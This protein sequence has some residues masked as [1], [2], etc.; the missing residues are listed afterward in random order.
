MH[1]I[2]DPKFDN[3]L[4][5]S[6]DE[7]KDSQVYKFNYKDK[8][9]KKWVD[10]SKKISIKAKNII[11]NEL[12]NPPSTNR[13]KQIGFISRPK[14]IMIDREPFGNKIKFKFNRKIF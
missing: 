13:D 3:L 11:D 4:I 14:D 6:F 2:L 7:I 10:L 12:L 1:L 9:S 8:D 5:Q